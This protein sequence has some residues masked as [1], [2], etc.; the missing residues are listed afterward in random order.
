M[1]QYFDI[2]LAIG[3]EPTELSTA[4]KNTLQNLIRVLLMRLDR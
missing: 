1:R 4:F 2:L 3:N